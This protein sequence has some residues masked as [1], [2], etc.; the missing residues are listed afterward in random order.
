MTRN[1]LASHLKWL[2]NQGPSL[3][4]S[5]TP[6]ARDIE[7]DDA[8]A[9]NAP[10]DDPAPPANFGTI[11]SAS[12]SIQDSQIPAGTVVEDFQ[13]NGAKIEDDDAEMARLLFDPQSSSKP[14]ML[15]CSKDGLSSSQKSKP[16]RKQEESPTQHRGAKHQNVVKGMVKFPAWRCIKE[17]GG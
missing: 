7:Y 8:I 14:R 4:P 13:E 15:S 1:N 2:L 6:S 11:H 3:Y 12:F 5:L 9:R 16:A 17:L 10:A